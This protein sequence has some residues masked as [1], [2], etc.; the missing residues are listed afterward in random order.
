M[1]ASLL[2]CPQ[3]FM[4]PIF[5]YSPLPNSHLGVQVFSSLSSSIV[6]L[7]HLE[8]PSLWWLERKLEELIWAL[9]CLIS[10]GH[11][12]DS[13]YALASRVL[14][15]QIN[16]IE[17]VKCRKACGLFGYVWSVPQ[18][19]NILSQASRSPDKITSFLSLNTATHTKNSQQLVPTRP[20]AWMPVLT[21]GKRAA[22]QSYQVAAYSEC[23][24]NKALYIY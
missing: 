16:Y 4:G 18:S 12:S 15:A 14:S 20:I 19:L 22:P 5:L 1:N 3:S 8:L 13:H 2:T 24:K 21:T 10:E 11:A 7:Y 17:T 9:T 23:T 6:W